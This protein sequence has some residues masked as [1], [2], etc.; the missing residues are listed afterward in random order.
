MRHRS[1]LKALRAMSRKESNHEGHEAHEEGFRRAFESHIQ[2]CFLAYALWKTLS[3]WMANAGLGHAPRT[4]LE[5]MAK[6]KSGPITLAA[7]RPKEA[8]PRQ[9]NLRCFAESN[10]APK[11]LLNRRN[12]PRRLQRFD[13][14]IQME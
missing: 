11:G 2:V 3:G 5:E 12:L 13:Q 1:P 9:I 7:N 14:P 8:Q 6:R 10:E 4:L